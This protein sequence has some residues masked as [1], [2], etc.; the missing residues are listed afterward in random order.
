MIRRVWLPV[1]VIIDLHAATIFAELPRGCLLRGMDPYVVARLPEAPSPAAQILSD[2]HELNGILG[3]RRSKLPLVHWL[4]NAGA[5]TLGRNEHEL[6][7][8]VLNL[9]WPHRP[10]GRAPYAS[11]RQRRSTSASSRHQARISGRLRNDLVVSDSHLLDACVPGAV[12]LRSVC[13]APPSRRADDRALN[14]VSSVTSPGGRA[15]VTRR[16]G[17]DTTP[18]FT[19]YELPARDNRTEHVGEALQPGGTIARSSPGDVSDED[20]GGDSIYLSKCSQASAKI[21]WRVARHTSKGPIHRALRS[22]VSS[23]DAA[24]WY[25]RPG[26][27]HYALAAS[28]LALTPILS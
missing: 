26:R 17:I 22:L 15:P 2:L 8:D 28:S 6:F 27:D 3:R 19:P 10:Q 11:A 23:G 21:R 16:D 12:A 4:L 20:H 7:H 5:L 18:P 9:L 14:L 24:Q 25:V 1:D 13:M